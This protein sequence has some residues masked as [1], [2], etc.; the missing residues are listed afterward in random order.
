MQVTLYKT[1]MEII[2]GLGPG[3]RGGAGGVAPARYCLYPSILEFQM[4][5]R[6]DFTI[7]EKGP[8]SSFIFKTCP[9]NILEIGMQ[10]QRS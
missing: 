9:L 3:R 8:T 5:V 7:T 10:V 4:K 6:E 1:N 2:A